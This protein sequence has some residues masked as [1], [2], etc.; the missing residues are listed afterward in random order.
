M[1]MDANIKILGEIH[2]PLLRRRLTNEYI[3]LWRIY[4]NNV[5]IKCA[6]S[7]CNTIIL[8][9]HHNNTNFEFTIGNEYPFKPPIL[10]VNG[11]LYTDYLCLSTKRLS[12]MYTKMYKISN[13]LCYSIVKN[14]KWKASFTIQQIINEYNN[15]KISKNNILLNIITDAIV[16]KYLI[17]DIDISSWLFGDSRIL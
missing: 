16:Y 12:N 6:C 11:Q 3:R 10:V 8:N 7:G 15:V 1:R 14:S 17:N 13:M 5:N 2:N 4:N 9:I